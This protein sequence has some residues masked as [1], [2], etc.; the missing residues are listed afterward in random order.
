MCRVAGWLTMLTITE[1]PEAS[2]RSAENLLS[3]LS[4]RTVDTG[5]MRL[6]VVED[7][8]TLGR[9]V[10]RGLEADGFSVDLVETGT[11]TPQSIPLPIA[12]ACRCREDVDIPGP[13]VGFVGGSQDIG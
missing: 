3:L 13:H 9:S 12:S 6:L 2:L 1:L 5:D 8:P 11:D 7:E 10:Q 4:G